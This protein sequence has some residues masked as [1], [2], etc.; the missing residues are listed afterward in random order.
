MRARHG[1]DIRASPSHTPS[2]SD[3]GING[4]EHTDCDAD[5]NPSNTGPDYNDHP[6]YTRWTAS[7][8]YRERPSPHRTL[9]GPKGGYCPPDL[10]LVLVYL[11]CAQGV[12]MTVL[13]TLAID[14]S[15]NTKFKSGTAYNPFRLPQGD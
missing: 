5:W 13:K 3:S 12:G 9:F 10:T 15:P 1:T 2:D 4:N 14:N 7:A 6:G 11:Q 8:S